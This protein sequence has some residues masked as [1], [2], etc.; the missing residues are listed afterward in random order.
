[1]TQVKH[2]DAGQ[3]YTLAH[4]SDPH[5]TALENVSPVDLCNK[6]ILGYLSWRSHRREEHR[7][8]VLQ[9]LVDDLREMRPDHTV[10]T[11]DMTHVGLPQ[12]CREVSAW[13]ASL[14]DPR[15]LTVIPGNHDAY[16]SAP[17]EK[18]MG[19][20]K[21]YMAPDAM[22]TAMDN[23]LFP[24]L[25]RRGPLALIGLSSACPTP[26]FF[27]TGRVGENQLA[28]LERLLRDTG[29]QGLIRVLLIHHPPMKQ[30]TGWRK[31]LTDGDALCDVIARHGVEVILHGHTH[32][33]TEAY[34]RT[35]RGEVPVIGVPSASG[36]G[37]K[38]GK[39]AQYH[40]CHFQGGPQGLRL[41]MT[42]RGYNVQEA[43]FVACGDRQ[44]RLA[45][46]SHRDLR[47]K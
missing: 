15:R 29:A 39:R 19:L 44:Y 43:R 18:T 24:V 35:G 26:P 1:M 3:F 21:P 12:E 46:I 32:R 45:R 7:P 20:W 33:S 25:R 40:L 14:S 17:W 4:L 6:R 13:L 10:I 47:N 31:R 37:L 16:V 23:A 34:L 28:S 41:H 42:V 2:K 8:E 22:A 36:I 27:A 11:G 9:A 38:P 30:A 5:L